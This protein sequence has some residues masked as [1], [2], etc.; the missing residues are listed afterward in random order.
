MSRVR[1]KNTKPEIKVRRAAHALGLRFRLHVQKLAGRPDLVFPKHRAVV[2]VHGC[3]WHRHPG[4]KKASFPKS[5]EEFW[6][7]KFDTNVQRDARIVSE[8]ANSGWRV[9]TIWECETK[10]DDLLREKLRTINQRART[11]EEE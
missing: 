3:F 7:S 8:L 2:F 5:R 4:C 9:V 6:Q 10:K 11:T 1:S